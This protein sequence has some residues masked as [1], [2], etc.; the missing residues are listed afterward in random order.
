[1]DSFPNFEPVR[2]SMSV[3]TVASWSAYRFLRRQVMW[4]GIPISLRI[5]HSFM[6]FTRNVLTDYLP[7]NIFHFNRINRKRFVVIGFLDWNLMRLSPCSLQTGS[8]VTVLSRVCVW[9]QIRHLIH[10]WLGQLNVWMKG[11][12]SLFL[13]GVFSS[14]LMLDIC[15]WELEGGL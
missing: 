4:F 15:W 14:G 5:F 3:L 2:C 7:I 8:W 11:Q 13:F 10:T 9:N 12:P 6:W 1:M